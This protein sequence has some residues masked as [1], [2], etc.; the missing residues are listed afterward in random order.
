M[1]ST[2]TKIFITGMESEEDADLIESELIAIGLDD[3]ECSFENAWVYVTLIDD[4]PNI[5]EVTILLSKLGFGMSG[6]VL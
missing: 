3:A 4:G 5:V 2:K 6:A 1:V